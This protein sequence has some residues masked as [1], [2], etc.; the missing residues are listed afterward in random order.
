MRHTFVLTAVVTV[1]VTMLGCASSQA[2]KF[3][4][5]VP[6]RT[7]TDAPAQ[8]V[9]RSPSRATMRTDICQSPLADEKSGKTFRL[10]RAQPGLGDYDVPVGLYGA[11][12]GELLRVDCRTLQPLGLVLR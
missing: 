4:R 3:P 1:L 5:D 7:L 11:R 12:Q 9:A 8:F 2:E 6:M 10:M